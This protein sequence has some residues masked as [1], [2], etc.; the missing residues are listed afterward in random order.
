MLVHFNL[1]KKKSVRE[2]VNTWLK[3]KTYTE[4][5]LKFTLQEFSAVLFKLKVNHIFNNVAIKVDNIASSKERKQNIDMHT[6]YYKQFV[7]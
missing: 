4:S 5:Y 3:V 6:T 2:C 1:C 7:Y